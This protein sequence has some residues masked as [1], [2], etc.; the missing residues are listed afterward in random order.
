MFMKRLSTLPLIA[1]A[2]ARA[3]GGVINPKSDKVFHQA[4]GH[5]VLP[6]VL[7]QLQFVQPAVD[8]ACNLRMLRAASVRQCRA[9]AAHDRL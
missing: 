4:M 9:R 1:R 2:G 7:H 5:P 3:S 8:P 6:L